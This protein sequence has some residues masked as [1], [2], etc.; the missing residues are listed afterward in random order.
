ME[1][2]RERLYAAD[3]GLSEIE[4]DLVGRVR[5]D[6]RT[7]PERMQEVVD[8]VWACA[9]RYLHVVDGLEAET[10]EEVVQVARHTG[11]LGDEEA[12]NA[13][14]VLKEVRTALREGYPDAGAADRHAR[15]LRL[16]LERVRDTAAKAEDA[17]TVGS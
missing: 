7:L 11:L 17:E 10:Q 9:Q 15:L 3:R 8:A 6:E 14:R 16:W 5:P 13:L 2:L 4:R 1:R 12:E